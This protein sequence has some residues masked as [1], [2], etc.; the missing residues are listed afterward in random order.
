MI[1]QRKKLQLGSCV[2]HNLRETR[3]GVR[4][5]R[6]EI[7]LHSEVGDQIVQLKFLIWR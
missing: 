1:L 4:I 7:F 3:N 2:L 6:G 5:F